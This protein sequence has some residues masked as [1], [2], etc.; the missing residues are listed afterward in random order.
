[1]PVTVAVT[2]LSDGRGPRHYE[3]TGRIFL[4][5][6]PL[7]PYA[8]MRFERLD[9]TM[10]MTSDQIKHA[11]RGSNLQVGRDIAPGFEFYYYPQ[12]FSKAIAAD[13]ERSRIFDEVRAVSEEEAAGYDYV[14]RGTLRATPL[15]TT[16]T[17]FCL[18]AAGVLLWLVPVPMGKTTASVELDL[19]LYDSRSGEVVW[20]SRLEH[21][22]HRYFMLY[23]SSAMIYGRHGAF[24]FNLVPPPSD[25]L[26]DRRSL[27]SWHFEALRRAMLP[28]PESLLHAMS[29]SAQNASSP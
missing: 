7:V 25:A 9:E 15:R 19:E 27:F 8:T 24:S 1:V 26:V 29:V 2:P 17:S 14:M 23:T 13:L 18:G 6:I 11:E 4:L 21:E 16:S 3:T 10:R 22:I 20:Q 12:S 28:V 5:Y